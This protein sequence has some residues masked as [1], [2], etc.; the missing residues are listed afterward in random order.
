MAQILF[1]GLSCTAAFKIGLFWLSAKAAMLISGV[2]PQGARNGQLT[3]LSLHNIL[4]SK[5]Y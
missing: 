1:T 4:Y 3:N 2:G 5:R